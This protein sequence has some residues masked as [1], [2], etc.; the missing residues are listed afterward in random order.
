MKIAQINY[1]CQKMAIKEL[2][3]ILKQLSQDEIVVCNSSGQVLYIEDHITLANMTKEILQQMELNVDH[4]TTAELGLDALIKKEYDLVLLDIILPG[5]MDGITMIKQIRL[6]TDHKNL[7]PILAISA[8]L[9]SNQRIHA[10][11]VG[12]N[13]FI[14]KPVLQ[15]EMAVRVKNLIVANQLYQQVSLQNEKLEKLAMTDQLTG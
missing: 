15:A 13:D 14:T 9:N 3:Q 1:I 7:V 8:A 11:K 12:A 5:K 10:L 4:F 2:K 6:R